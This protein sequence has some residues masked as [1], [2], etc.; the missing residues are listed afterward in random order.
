VIP[1][2]SLLL[3]CVLSLPSAHE[4]AGATG[5]RHSPRP[6]WGRKIYQRLGRMA[7]RDCEVMSGVA[8]SLRAKRS[9]PCRRVKEEWIASSLA[10]LAMTATTQI[11]P[12]CPDLI[13]A[14]INLRNKIFRRRWIAGSSPAM[15]ASDISCV[16]TYNAS[17]TA[18]AISAVPLLPPNSIGLIPAA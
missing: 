4:A 5:A 8:T 10:L 14:S 1:V 2:Y 11:H 15:T 7:R 6:P 17:S 16:L 18:F 13:R 9:N 12:S 3:V